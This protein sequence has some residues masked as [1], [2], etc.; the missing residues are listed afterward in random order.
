MSGGDTCDSHAKG[1]GA[2][3]ALGGAR[4][5][6]IG[7]EGIR[8][9]AGVAARKGGGTG[10]GGHSSSGIVSGVASSILQASF[11]TLRSGPGGAGVGRDGG[12]GGRGGARG[13]GMMSQMR[14]GR[15]YRDT[16]EG[17]VGSG[18]RGGVS[19]SGGSGGGN[20]DENYTLERVIDSGSNGTVYLGVD[21]RSGMR[22][23]IKHVK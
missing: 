19:R 9:V 11:G 12:D 8:D 1:L 17:R 16:D 15:G 2:F 23:H 3:G 4:Q 13:G 6:A 18:E 21:K 22:T 14:G 5:G 10:A 20:I 7:K